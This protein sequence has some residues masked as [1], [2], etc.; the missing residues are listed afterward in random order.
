MLKYPYSFNVA[1]YRLGK[2]RLEPMQPA[3]SPLTLHD[4]WGGPEGI[5]RALVLHHTTRA[6]KLAD[7]CLSFA[8]LASESLRIFAW[9]IALCVSVWRFMSLT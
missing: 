1:K 7:L 4:L 9:I 3:V 6:V 5:C 8:A 2:F